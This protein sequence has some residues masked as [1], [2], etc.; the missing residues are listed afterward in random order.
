MEPPIWLKS[1]FLQREGRPIA[2]GNPENNHRR[3][4]NSYKLR[5]QAEADAERKS[6]YNQRN[7]RRKQNNRN[8]QQPY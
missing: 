5:H 2:F 1:I 7:Q 4:F 8:R 3:E 6:V